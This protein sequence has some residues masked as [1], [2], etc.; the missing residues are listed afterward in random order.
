[1]LQSGPAHDYNLYASSRSNTDDN[2]CTLSRSGFPNETTVLS[3]PCGR[4]PLFLVS[5]LKC[6]LVAWPC[7]FFGNACYTD[8][9]SILF[10]KL[11]LIRSLEARRYS[12]SPRVGIKG[13]PSPTS[14]FL[15]HPLSFLSHFHSHSIFPKTLTILLLSHSYPSSSNARSSRSGHDEDLPRSCGRSCGRRWCSS[16]DNCKYFDP[17]NQPN[18]TEHSSS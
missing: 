17:F 6:L 8:L 1:M 14:F 11:P 2:L 12:G 16:L 7:E 3:S 5:Q 13:L 10:P 15:S 4:P 18:P 9:S